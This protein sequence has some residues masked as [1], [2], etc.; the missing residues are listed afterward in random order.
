MI[1]PLLC[2][3][4]C[5]NRISPPHSARHTSSKQGSLLVSCK[6]KIISNLSRWSH[7]KSFLRLIDLLSP[8]YSTKPPEGSSM[9][10]WYLLK[11][12]HSFSGLLCVPHYANR[13]SVFF[14]RKS[15]S[16]VFG[17]CKLQRIKVNSNSK[18]KTKHK[19]V[20]YFDKNFST[21]YKMHIN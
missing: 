6:K 20:K 3:E 9:Y 21:C 18:M 17:A 19:K 2:L 12:T 10:F 5:A 11:F 16:L 13:D 1:T 7:R 15:C 14:S 8:L 4:P